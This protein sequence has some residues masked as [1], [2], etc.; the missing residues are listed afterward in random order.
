MKLAAAGEKLYKK[1]NQRMYFVRKLKKCH[2]DKSIMSMFYKSVVES[3][4]NFGLL[5]WYGQE[6]F[7]YLILP[8]NTHIYP[9]HVRKKLKSYQI[10]ASPPQQ[11]T[12]WQLNR[13]SGLHTHKEKLVFYGHFC[14]SVVYTV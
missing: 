11:L 12:L 9:C 2:I 1:A 14:Q 13:I 5:N 3:V 4:L 10:V 7:K 8:I 6:G